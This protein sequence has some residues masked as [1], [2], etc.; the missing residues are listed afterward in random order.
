MNHIDRSSEQIQADIQRTRADLDRTLTQ[1]ERR[2]EPRRLMDQ[3]IDFLRDNGAREYFSNLGQAAKDQPLPIALVGVG[4]AWMMMTNGRVRESRHDS[5][6]LGDTLGSAAASAGE[7]IGEGVD[8]MS[9]RA[10]ELTGKVSGAAS[11]LASQTRDAAQRT[12]QSLAAAADATRARAAQVGEATR[13]SAQKLRNGYDRLV[14]EEPLALGAIGLVLGA[15]LAAAA[16]RTRPEDEWM[17]SS[18]DKLLDDAKRV[19]TEKLQEVKDAISEA[20]ERASEAEGARDDRSDAN[21]P[22]P[23]HDSTVQQRYE[24][25]QTLE[26]TSDVRFRPDGP[27]QPAVPEPARAPL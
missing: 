12:S 18:S 26:Q 22:P 20:S 2:L 8:A 13:E 11:Q 4:L 9:S 14:S 10:S 21:S 5:R 3:G 16:P 6:A 23:M 1:L 27:G 7:R 15:V 25:T 19:G 24:G 17:G